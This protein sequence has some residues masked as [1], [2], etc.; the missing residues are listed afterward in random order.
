M[1]LGQPISPLKEAENISWEKN[2]DMRKIGADKKDN[3]E[4]LVDV[5][6]DL[7][8]IFQTLNPMRTQGTLS[9]RTPICAA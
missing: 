9:T 7:R 6:A 8:F 1:H 4:A 2:G 3:I 5:D